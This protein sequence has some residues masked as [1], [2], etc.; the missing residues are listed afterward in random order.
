MELSRGRWLWTGIPFTGVVLWHK[1]LSERE[2]PGPTEVSLCELRQSESLKSNI[3]SDRPNQ[4]RTQILQ[5]C[6]A[7]QRSSST[8]EKWCIIVKKY[9]CSVVSLTRT[10]V[11]LL[12]LISI[13]QHADVILLTIDSLR[14]RLPDPGSET[15]LGGSPFG[16]L[17]QQKVHHD[18]GVVFTAPG[19]FGFL[20]L[21]SEYPIEAESQVWSQG[22]L[23]V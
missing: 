23:L 20:A 18:F 6:L 21:D 19:I 13:L 8:V 16:F 5:S 14:N 11:M 10:V 17:F 3:A 2:G 15:S 9:L 22:R 4:L 7:W 12:H 1:I